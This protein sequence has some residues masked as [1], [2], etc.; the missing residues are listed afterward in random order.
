MLPFTGFN[1]DDK[2]Q[3]RY[4]IRDLRQELADTEIE[5]RNEVHT[6]TTTNPDPLSH[7][8]LVP[9]YVDVPFVRAS[10]D[11]S[12]GTKRG[13][14]LTVL[15]DIETHDLYAGIVLNL[16]EVEAHQEYIADNV[17]DAVNYVVE[18]DLQLWASRNSVNHWKA[19]VAKTTDPAE[20]R[21]WLGS[22]SKDTIRAGGKDYKKAMFMRKCSTSEP[23]TLVQEAKETLLDFHDQ[24]LCSDNLFSRPTL[25]DY[26]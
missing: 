19:G 21:S 15:I 10:R 14:H 1:H 13:S 2:R 16:R 26:E 18:Q 22:G 23:A 8:R 7:K 6:W 9:K 20:M 24:F 5:N 3:Y 4:F 12:S 17:D 11:P 25:E